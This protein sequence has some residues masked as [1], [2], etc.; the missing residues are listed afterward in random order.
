[1]VTTVE[2]VLVMT[3]APAIYN[4]TGSIVPGML[5]AT[6]YI[7]KALPSCCVLDMPFLSACNPVI[8]WYRRTVTFDPLV[9]LYFL[10]QCSA[11]VELCL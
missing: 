3:V 4:T 2:V 9:V 1:M 10:Q 6:L 7:L 8:D 11:A 5:V